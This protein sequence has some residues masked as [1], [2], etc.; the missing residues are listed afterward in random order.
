V[1][2]SGGSESEAS[3]AGWL[4]VAR[5]PPGVGDQPEGFASCR[6]RSCRRLE[7]CSDDD[8]LLPDV[9]DVATLLEVMSHS[10]KIV[11]RVFGG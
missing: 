2:A 1:A 11:D 5:V 9:P 4:T 6:R 7:G 3:E 8:P 10:K